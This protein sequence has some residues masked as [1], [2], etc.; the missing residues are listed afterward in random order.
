MSRSKNAGI[1]PRGNDCNRR[2]GGSRRR[3]SLDWHAPTTR[4]ALEETYGAEAYETARQWIE[5]TE[6]GNQSVDGLHPRD[7]TEA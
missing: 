5:E 3:T 7:E 1:Y 6:A 2:P 4:Q